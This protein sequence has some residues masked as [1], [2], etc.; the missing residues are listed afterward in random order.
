M[1]GISALKAIDRKRIS[2]KD[3]RKYSDSLD[4]DSALESSCPNDPRWDYG[5]GY[6]KTKTDEVAVWVEVHPANTGEVKAMI[7]K[8]DW[9]KKWLQNEATELGKLTKKKHSLPRFNWV[10]SGKIAL[11]KGSK[12]AR[13]LAQSGLSYPV[14]H[15]NFD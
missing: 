6:K 15:L 9:L 2:A 8:L 7:K 13:L 1:P 14:K 5:I 3:P 12:Q 11:P 4:L 10:A